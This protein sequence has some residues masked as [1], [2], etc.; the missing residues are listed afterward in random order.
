MKVIGEVY[1]S[2]GMKKDFDP[3]ERTLSF[4]EMIALDYFLKIPTGESYA[5]SL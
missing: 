2:R 1:F 4:K 3:Q 5:W